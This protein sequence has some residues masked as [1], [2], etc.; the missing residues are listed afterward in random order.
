MRKPPA[1]GPGPDPFWP[2]ASPPLP[3]WCGGS[4]RHLYLPPL[5][6]ALTSRGR[7]GGRSLRG[8]EAACPIP[9]RAAAVLLGQPPLVEEGCCGGERAGLCAWKP[10]RGLCYAMIRCVITLTTC[11]VVVCLRGV[12][13]VVAVLV[14]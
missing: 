6:T 13:V 10:G 2:P 11:P 14:G 4:A 5:Q 7:A 1:A 8:R 12:V 3:P 9:G